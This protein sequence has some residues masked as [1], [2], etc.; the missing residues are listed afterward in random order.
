MTELEVIAMNARVV[1]AKRGIF[2]TV[3]TGKSLIYW[4]VVYLKNRVAG[5]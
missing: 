3:F 5:L 2:M 4:F 1:N